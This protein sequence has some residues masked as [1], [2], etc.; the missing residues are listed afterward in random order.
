MAQ[1]LLLSD[2]RLLRAGQAY[3]INRFQA[4]WNP[5]SNREP[6]KS[7]EKHKHAIATRLKYSP[8]AILC[9]AY[10]LSGSDAVQI[11]IIEGLV[12]LRT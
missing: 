10:K 5:I 1:F 6:R 3:A 12:L 2:V 4:L 8:D 7:N 9:L 11:K